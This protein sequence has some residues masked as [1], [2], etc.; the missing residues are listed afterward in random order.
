MS[1]SM[2]PLLYVCA[3]WKNRTTDSMRRVRLAIEAAVDRGWAPIFAPFL[4][5]VR[6]AD[7]TL[8]IDDSFELDRSI[9][10]EIDHA[11]LAKCDAFVVVSES[12][13]L[14]DGMRRDLDAWA[15][16]LRPTFD[17]IYAI[18]MAKESSS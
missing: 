18:P 7:G 3:P 13:G 9:A 15:P 4:L 14:S 8:L 10:F 6:R 11:I 5:D 1:D 2:R 12:D 16:L 17:G